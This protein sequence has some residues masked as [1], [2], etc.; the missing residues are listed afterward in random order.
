VNDIACCF[1]ET[2]YNEESCFV[3]ET[4]FAGAND[5]CRA[6]SR[7]VAEPRIPEDRVKVINQLADEVMKIYDLPEE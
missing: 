4:Y 1:V 3:R 5:P 7:P 6:R 2:N